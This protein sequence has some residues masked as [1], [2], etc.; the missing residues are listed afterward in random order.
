M[1]ALGASSRIEG[2]LHGSCLSY[3]SVRRATAPGQLSVKETLEA[4]RKLLS[5]VHA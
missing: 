2:F 1:G 3:A 4:Q 5:Q